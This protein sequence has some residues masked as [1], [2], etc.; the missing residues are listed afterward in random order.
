MLTNLEG[1]FCFIMVPTFG[2]AATWVLNAA[3]NIP[4]K[5]NNLSRFENA[6]ITRFSIRNALFK[7]HITGLGLPVLKPFD[8]ACRITLY[9]NNKVILV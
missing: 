9:L 1:I 7:G 8:N 5:V 6:V 2:T 4:F 3:C